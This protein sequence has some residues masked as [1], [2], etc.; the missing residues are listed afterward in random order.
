[1]TEQNFDW[2]SDLIM[3]EQ[4]KVRDAQ[5]DYILEFMR[6]HNLTIADLQ[7]DYE[8]EETIEYPDF[9]LLLEQNSYQWTTHYRLKLK[10]KTD[11]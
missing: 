3:R 1:M 6:V 10:E 8:L 4:Q 7:R 2:I 9:D 11:D 5:N